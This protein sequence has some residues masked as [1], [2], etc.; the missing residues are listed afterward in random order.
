MTAAH[1]RWQKI[2]A[3]WQK[4]GIACCISG[5]LQAL[6]GRRKRYSLTCRPC[7]ML[8]LHTHAWHADK[9]VADTVA[10]PLLS[11]ICPEGAFACDDSL[12]AFMIKA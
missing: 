10:F 2:A 4:L 3:L 5:V 8:R 1:V 7:V 6:Y 12:V 9:L 11:S